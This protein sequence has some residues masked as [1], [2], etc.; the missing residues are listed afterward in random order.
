MTAAMRERETDGRTDGRGETQR[1]GENEDREGRPAALYDL[2]WQIPPEVTS[3]MVG[4]REE[5]RCMEDGG[6]RRQLLFC[7]PRRSALAL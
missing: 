5:E 6:L 1:Q 3:G 4:V 2:A 7:A